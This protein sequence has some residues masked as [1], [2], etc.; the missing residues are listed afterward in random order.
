MAA[1][2]NFFRPRDRPEPTP[3]FRLVQRH[4]IESALRLILGGARGSAS[5]EQVLDFLTFAIARKID[6]NQI[7]IASLDE[8]IEWALLPVASPGRSTLIFSPCRL[9]RRGNRHLIG[10]LL[11]RLVADQARQNVQMLQILLDPADSELA[12]IYLQAGFGR[13]AD[14]T[15]L[16]ANLRGTESLPALP[17]GWQMARYDQRTHVLFVQTIAR[18]YE[19]SRDCPALTGRRDMDDVIAGHQAAGDFDP[20]LWFLLRD[21]DGLACGTLLLSR[22]AGNGQ[23]E[24]VY[25]GLVP[26]ARGKGLGDLLIRWALAVAALE[27]RKHLSLAVDAA[28]EPALRLYYRHG[29]ARVGTRVALLYDLSPVTPGP[30]LA[31]GH[32]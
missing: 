2:S 17:S 25:I 4:E 6:V 24:L 1:L 23:A 12:Q 10:A 31:T 7:W 22:S 21:P 11:H 16:Q 14:L 32:A 27:G 20:N 5:D 8:R 9:P 29:F 19:G 30:T 26:E 18:S 13:L 15:Y 3:A 28:N